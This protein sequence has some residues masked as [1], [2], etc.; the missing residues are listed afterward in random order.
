[1]GESRVPKSILYVYEFGNKRLRGRPRNRWKEEVR[2]NGRIVGAEELLEKVYNREERKK[3][4][5]TAMNC[6]ILHMGKQL[7][8]DK[9]GTF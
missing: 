8:N 6:C 7:I 4:L 5:K 2:E 1:M 3:P 9:N